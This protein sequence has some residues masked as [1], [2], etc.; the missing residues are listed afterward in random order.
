VK[1]KE[2]KVGLFSAMALIM[3]YYGFDFL[4][5]RDFFDSTNKYYAIYENVDEL[6]KSSQVLVNG[7]AVGRVSNIRIMQERQNKVL[8]ELEIDSEIKLG[9]STRAILNSDFLGTKSIVLDI[10][11]VVVPL[12]PK[13]T[14]IAELPIGVL[15]QLTASAAPVADNLQTTLRKLNTVLDNLANNSQALDSIFHNF[16]KTPI[17]LN[18]TIGKQ[19][20]NVDSLTMALRKTSEHLNETMLAFRPVIKNMQVFTD[21]LKRIEMNQTLVKTQK[22]VEDFSAIVKKL[23][24][25]DNTASK[26]LTEDS[27]YVNL[28][29]L[30]VSVDS[31]ARHFDSNPRD[32]L[33]PLGKSQKKIE[34]ERA[35]RNKK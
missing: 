12:E 21:S 11:K 15:D 10:G 35:D 17:L 19:S 20:A 24:D 32:F 18:N 33:K 5:G 27:L 23:G 22:A 25:G 34:K 2:L 7:F 3:L 31:L 13:D 4:K 6:T 30:L 16:Q 9:D 8:V 28:N 14:I 1:S 26:L 29:K